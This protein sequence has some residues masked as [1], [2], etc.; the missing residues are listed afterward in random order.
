MAES[1]PDEGEFA[2]EQGAAEADHAF[3]VDGHGADFPG[4]G[5]DGDTPG[6]PVRGDGDPK[7]DADGGFAAPHLRVIDQAAVRN[8]NTAHAVLRT[9]VVVVGH[10]GKETLF[11]LG[12]N[13]CSSRC[14]TV[15]GRLTDGDSP[16]DEEFLS[17]FRLLTW[18]QS[19]PD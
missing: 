17:S 8:D 7:A 5:V 4:V 12:L 9:G 2:Q 6:K 16:K 15:I 13:H 18:P 1:V 10:I 11:G 14:W 3:A 19:R